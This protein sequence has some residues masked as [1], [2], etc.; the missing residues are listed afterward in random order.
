MKKLTLVTFPAATSP[1]PPAWPGWTSTEWQA[2]RAT[3]FAQV[4]A[5][6]NTEVYL[7]T[8]FLAD[9]R[10]GQAEITR[11]AEPANADAIA[12]DA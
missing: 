11:D 3:W 2:V 10:V 6:L 7:K 4:D 8:Y 9:Q 1:H 12:M 5:V